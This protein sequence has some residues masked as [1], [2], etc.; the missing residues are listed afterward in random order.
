MG[1]IF[2]YNNKYMKKSKLSWA[3]VAPAALGLSVAPMLTITSCG[4]TSVSSLE[5]TSRIGNIAFQG[6]VISR[7]DF[8]VTAIKNDGSKVY[9][10]GWKCDKLN[11][12]SGTYTVTKQ[13]VDEG[14]VKFT[15]SYGGQSKE[16]RL[17][18]RE[19]GECSF[20]LEVMHLFKNNEFVTE[21][22]IRLY[23]VGGLNPQPIDAAEFNF[24]FKDKYGKELTG[25]NNIFAVDTINDGCLLHIKE[26][27]TF[28]D[29]DTYTIEAY[30]GDTAEAVASAEIWVSSTEYAKFESD[31][32]NNATLFASKGIS[33][34][35]V[36]P[37]YILHNG[38]QLTVT[39]LTH[40]DKHNYL[41][42]IHSLILPKS[43]ETIE[44]GLFN[45]PDDQATGALYT[46]E[47]I[48]FWGTSSDWYYV[49]AGEDW[50][51]KHVMGAYC[52]GDWQ[53]VNFD[54]HYNTKYESKC[55]T[56]ESSAL[57]CEEWLG[58]VGKNKY[59]IKFDYSLIPN[60]PETYTKIQA[61]NQKW[62]P[63]TSGDFAPRA[64]YLNGKKLKKGDDYTIDDTAILKRGF[65]I[66][67]KVALDAYS[68]VV[69][70]LKTPS[71]SPSAVW[72]GAHA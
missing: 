2:L 72:I 34:V 17:E 15:F 23:A 48:W 6:S 65:T 64:I 19:I 52:L 56:I 10:T 41:T 22:E 71:L 38:T 27:K 11:N 59:F 50:Q 24:R 39:G 70:E 4:N 5:V 45:V 67:M 21:K 46:L 7:T 16:V 9:P 66:N 12:K 37:E 14:E 29:N 58:S 28:I 57:S 44:K 42:D 47:Y 3:L 62:A 30:Y 68:K 49:N 55:E 13:D 63:L 33:N 53:Y 35:L 60:N 1:V 26:G 20:G 8:V 61:I 36:V 32:S 69:V 40:D 54:N 51:G 43:I 18:A 31:S 25:D